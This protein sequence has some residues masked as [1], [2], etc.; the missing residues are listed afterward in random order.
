MVEVALNTPFDANEIKEIACQEFRKR[1]DGLSPLT[2]GKEYVAFSID[3]SHKIR[4]R[5]AGE[6]D[7]EVRETLAWGH[8]GSNFKSLDPN[9]ER[10]ERDMALTVE[11]GDGRGG[12][13]KKKVRVKV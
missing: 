13:I 6:Q 4:L 5:R 2:G 12:K 7:H 3:F 1:L 10:M 9:E 11:T 8:V